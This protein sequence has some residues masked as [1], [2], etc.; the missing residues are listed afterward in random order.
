MLPFLRL[1]TN[2]PNQARL[3]GGGKQSLT[4]K[5]NVCI[6]IDLYRFV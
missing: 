6:C 2:R 5:D 3:E 4:L 1:N